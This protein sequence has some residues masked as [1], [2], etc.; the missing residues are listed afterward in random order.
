LTGYCAD[1]LAAR[2]GAIRAAHA[3]IEELA[4]DREL[5]A[6]L[7]DGLREHHGARFRELERAQAETDWARVADELALELI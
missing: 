3:H 7:V 1:E 5:P 6:D 2:M 4:Q